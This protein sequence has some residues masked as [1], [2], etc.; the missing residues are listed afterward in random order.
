MGAKAI[1]YGADAVVMHFKVAEQS[2][3]GPD[4]LPP[5]DKLQVLKQFRWLLDAKQQE[6]LHKWFLGHGGLSGHLS[7]VPAL[8]DSAKDTKVL[9]MF[10]YLFRLPSK[11]FL[12]F[13]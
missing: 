7:R 11:P 6:V 5:I 12:G 13:L 8:R 4:K 2:A 10:S 3:D 9:C 1:L